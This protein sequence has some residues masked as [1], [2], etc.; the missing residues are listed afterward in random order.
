V[1]TLALT[2]LAMFALRGAVN[3]SLHVF[4]QSV[5]LNTQA[6]VVFQNRTAAYQAMASLAEG[7][8]EE[9]EDVRLYDADGNLL[10][11][12]HRRQGSTL[13]QSLANASVGW[14][15]PAPFIQPIMHDGGEIGSIRIAAYGGRMAK[16]LVQGTIWL[17][18][19]LSLSAVCVFYF[20]RKLTRDIIT[21]LRQFANV[22]HAIRD[23]RA[24][25]R[26][27]PEAPISELDDLGRD[28]N[29]L[30]AEL[31][32]WERKNLQERAQ[33]TIR[34]TR[35]DLTGLTKR[36]AFNEHLQRAADRALDQGHCIALL[37]IDVDHF[38]QVNDRLGHA[39]GDA[40]LVAI[41]ERLKAQLREGDLAARLG[42]DEFA[43]VLQSLHDANDATRIAE[44]LVASMEE[45]IVL[46]HGEAFKVSISV[47]VSVLP[48]HGDS[49]ERLMA[50]ADAA[51]YSA[52]RDP[53]R[54][55]HMA[56]RKADSDNKGDTVDEFVD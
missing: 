1:T 17:L 48:D 9:V 51:M 16:F 32:V 30:L 53:A 3:R 39:A 18:L 19:G 14:L 35:D 40:I 27:V 44:R 45:P 24:F 23:E 15:M 47:G 13:L 2:L 25:D 38:K 36:A 29:A 21:P 22:T 42:G 5:S 11:R 26:R 20:S 43:I 55:W 41:A 52:K 46:A 31:D 8:S 12:W 28:F 7:N 33:L 56:G 50:A 6:A 54:G 34:A 10:A 4:A 49:I 37:F